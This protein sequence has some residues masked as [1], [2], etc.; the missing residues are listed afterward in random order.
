M[1][2][3]YGNFTFTFDNFAAHANVSLEKN[4]DSYIFHKVKRDVRVEKAKLLLLKGLGLDIQQGRR[5]MPKSEAFE[6]LRTNHFTLKEAGIEVR[7]SAGNGKRYFLGY[8]SIDHTNVKT[9]LATLA[10]SK[11]K[12]LP[13]GMPER[14]QKLITALA[15]KSGQEFDRDYLAAVRTEHLKEVELIKNASENSADAD[16]KAFAVKALPRMLYHTEMVERL[17]K[18]NTN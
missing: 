16:I 4:G 17:E 7:Q 11:K 2:F 3:R 15:A 9:D 18:A 1:S 8:S 14:Y 5:K 10:K 12:N 13:V 6:W